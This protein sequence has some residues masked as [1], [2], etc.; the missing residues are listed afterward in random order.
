ML[1]T[2]QMGKF[3]NTL[4]LLVIAIS[5]LH[6]VFRGADY[7]ILWL[8][9][10]KEKTPSFTA[11]L[12]SCLIQHALIYYC[13]LNPKG[14]NMNIVRFLFI[15][16]ILDIFHLIL[17]SYYGFIYE[18]LFLALVLSYLYNKYFKND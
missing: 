7:K 17:L 12:A 9:N 15:L 3:K 14:V 4:L 11:F 1:Q 13:L 6:T 10:N 18:K 16:S 2:I 8:I 5:Q